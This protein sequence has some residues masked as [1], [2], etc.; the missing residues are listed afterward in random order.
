MSDNATVSLGESSLGESS[1][2]ESRS[3]TPVSLSDTRIEVIPR[4][5]AGLMAALAPLRRQLV[6]HE[7]YRRLVDVDDLALF[8]SHHIFAVWDFMSLL[9]ALQRELTCVDVPWVPKGSSAARR[10]VNELVLAEESDKLPDGRILSHFELYREA[11]GELGA[12]GGPIDDFLARLARGQ[13]VSEAITQSGAPCHGRSF[14]Q[15]TWRI[16]KSRSLPM[17]AAAFTL[18]R[19]DVIPDM[20]S[21]LVAGLAQRHPARARTLA[22]YF[23]RHVEL[24]GDEHGPASLRM[25]EGILGTDSAAWSDAYTAARAALK[26]RLALWDGLLAQLSAPANAG[27]GC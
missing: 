4:D 3:P 9:K 24:D 15:T 26:A 8:A 6:E 23:Q 22:L 14:V 13:G 18:G 16:V 5:L 12:D 21:Q 27:G 20:F 2:G 19:E 1:L 17:I 25:L 10:I 7:L 11:M